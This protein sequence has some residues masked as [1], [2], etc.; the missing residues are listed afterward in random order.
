MM[1]VR[2]SPIYIG[3]LTLLMIMLGMRVSMLRNKFKVSLVTGDRPELQRAV[4]VF[5]NMA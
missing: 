3:I 2:A 4:R 1:E 5:G